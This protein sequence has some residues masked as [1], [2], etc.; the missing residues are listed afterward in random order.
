MTLLIS[1]ITNT[2][3]A[4]CVY[5]IVFG[6][7]TFDI[8]QDSLTNQTSFIDELLKNV[9]AQVVYVLG[10]VYAIAFVLSKVSDLWKRHEINKIE[11]KKS[12]EHL[13]QEELTT[14]KQRK[15]LE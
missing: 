5:A 2:T 14:E 6:M 12:K 1:I 13:E 3:I 7:S 15:D 11:V 8:V 4:K 10:I 9:P